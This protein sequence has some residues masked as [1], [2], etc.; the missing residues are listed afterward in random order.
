MSLSTPSFLSLPLLVSSVIPGEFRHGFTTREGGVSAAPFDTLNLGMKWGDS[1]DNVLEN[2]RRVLRA[3]G[4]GALYFASQVHGAAVARVR[5]GDDATRIAAV[6]ADAVCSDAPG[7]A[8]AVY[9]ADCV[10]MLMVDPRTGAFAAVHAGWRGAVADVPGATVRE[11]GLQFGAAAADVKVAM[12]PAIGVCCFEVGPE[13]AAA[14]ETVVPEAR[15]H[16]VIVEAPGRKPHVD[17]RRACQLVLQGQGVPAASIDVAPA[18]THC[19]PGGRFYSYRRDAAR[20]GQ[21]MAFVCR[22]G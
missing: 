15:R 16:G 22:E 21:H 10:P 19:D 20:T 8:V 1:R 9:V 2:R 5:A 4:A 3:S 14:F 11:L 18:C 6:A 13:V 17:I 12:G 7:L